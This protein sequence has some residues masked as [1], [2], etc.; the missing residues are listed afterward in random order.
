[1]SRYN[2]S[3]A[4]YNPNGGI[5]RVAADAKATNIAERKA[6]KNDPFLWNGIAFLGWA[7][8][9]PW[10]RSAFLNG[11]GTC[12]VLDGRKVVRILS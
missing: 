11:K 8:M 4:P 7:T 5:S 2:S 1:M 3:S 9:A 10:E 12:K 6:L